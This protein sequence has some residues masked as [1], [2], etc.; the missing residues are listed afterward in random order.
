MPRPRPLSPGRGL[1]AQAEAYAQGEGMGELP[2]FAKPQ[3]RLRRSKPSL[4]L[5]L[6]LVLPIAEL[7][8]RC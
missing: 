1:Y 6:P 5:S 2:P 8:G 7:D 3:T 4:G